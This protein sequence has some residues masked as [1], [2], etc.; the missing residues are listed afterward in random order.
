M[1]EIHATSGPE[2]RAFADELQALFIR[3]GW[4]VE[5]GRPPSLRHGTGIVLAVPDN[6]HGEVSTSTRKGKAVLAKVK[7]QASIVEAKSPEF[8]MDNFT[9]HATVFVLPKLP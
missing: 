5:M 1:I 3:A 8:L 2:E 4:K 6:A 9:V 7:F